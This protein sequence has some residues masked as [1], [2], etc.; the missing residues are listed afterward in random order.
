MSGYG[1]RGHLQYTLHFK[2][3]PGTLYLA[4]LTRLAARWY[5]PL[6]TLMLLQPSSPHF[7]W[8]P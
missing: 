8:L 1:P 2:P 3:P 7:F 6:V 5:C 4:Y